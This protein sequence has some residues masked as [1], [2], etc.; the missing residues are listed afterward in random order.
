LSLVLVLAFS[1]T[2]LGKSKSSL[3]NSCAD[4]DLSRAIGQ[5]NTILRTSLLSE[6]NLAELVKAQASNYKNSL[7]IHKVSGSILFLDQVLTAGLAIWTLPFWGAVF[8]GGT[9][10]SLGGDSS[11]M[12]E[13]G[14]DKEGRPVWT[15]N[16]PELTG[17]FMPSCLNDK[18][19]YKLNA[20]WDELNDG[21]EYKNQKLSS[22]QKVTNKKDLIETGWSYREAFLQYSQNK[23]RYEY[24]KILLPLLVNYCKKLD[25]LDVNAL[26][27]S[28][29]ELRKALSS[30]SYLEDAF[31]TRQTRKVLNDIE[32]GAKTPAKNFSI[33][34]P[35]LK[36]RSQMMRI[37]ENRALERA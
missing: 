16:A 3:K 8:V 24:A 27:G 30:P 33:D 23:E 2:A 13:I 11:K 22:L 17:T 15:R 37:N 6:K 9:A 4:P 29:K 28:L 26:N 34:V 10:G 36:T 12:P 19:R 18:C 5:A 32:D 14:I 20:E 31:A 1:Q 7:R 21:L 25:R 35:S